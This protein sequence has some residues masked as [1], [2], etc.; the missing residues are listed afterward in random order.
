M[1]T[2]YRRTVAAYPGNAALQTP[3]LRGVGEFRVVDLDGY[4]LLDGQPDRSAVRGAPPSAER[5]STLGV[6]AVA[7]AHFATSTARDSRITITFT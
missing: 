5:A 2:W 4:V 1:V 6:T 3:G 7:T